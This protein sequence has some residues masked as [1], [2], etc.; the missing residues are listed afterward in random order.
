[1]VLLNILLSLLIGLL[2]AATLT[3]G[4]RRRAGGPGAGF[5][6]F[7]TIL[8][9][10]SWVG[11]VWIEPIGPELWGVPWVAMILVGLIAALAIAALTSPTPREPTAP[12]QNGIMP[13]NS[14]GR[15]CSLMFWMISAVMV[16]AIIARYTW[17]NTPTG[18]Q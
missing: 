5:V 8:F 4:L 2:L 13:P 10:S 18:G 3:W 16:M 17:F 7:A 1:M 11:A 9:L 6:F 12:D 15:G 14:A